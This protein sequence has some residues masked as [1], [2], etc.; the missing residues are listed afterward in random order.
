MKRSRMILITYHCVLNSNA[1]VYPLALVEGVFTHA[2]AAVIREGLGLFQLPCPEVSYLG[3]N[4]W[5]MTREQYDHPN[6]RMHCREIL[7]YPLVQIEAFLKAGYRI[8]GLIGMDGSPNCGL[9]YTCEGY[10]GGEICSPELVNAQTRN[11]R[12]TPGKGVFISIFLESMNS[13]GEHPE[14]R[15]VEEQPETFH[16]N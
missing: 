16:D 9:N 12:S 15:T 14:I 3:L 1:K 4:R 2:V 6:F 10:T 13:L 5:G 8:D 7:R 11:L